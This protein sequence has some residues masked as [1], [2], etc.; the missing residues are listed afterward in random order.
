MAYCVKYA[1]RFIGSKRT[2]MLM[3][4][5]IIESAAFHHGS[6]RMIKDCNEKLVCRVEGISRFVEIVSKGKFKTLIQ[7]LPDGS[8]L[9]DSLT[10]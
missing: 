9:V 6:F 5:F 7:F 2:E 10:I 4:R 3:N 1:Y 8:V